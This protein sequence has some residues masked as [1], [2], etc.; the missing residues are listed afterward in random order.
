MTGPSLENREF[1]GTYITSGHVWTSPN[2]RRARVWTRRIKYYCLLLDRCQWVVRVN[3]DPGEWDGICIVT[4]WVAIESGNVN[5]N[6]YF[7][8]VLIGQSSGSRSFYVV[9]RI[10]RIARAWLSLPDLMTDFSRNYV[11]NEITFPKT[12]VTIE[13]SHCMTKICWLL[14]IENP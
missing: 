13:K 9:T 5:Q 7:R 11:L 8:M 6:M 4:A 14:G 10:V 1:R 3:K 12:R 2:T